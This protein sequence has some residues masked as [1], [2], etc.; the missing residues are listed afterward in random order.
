MAYTT[1]VRMF[2]K[3]RWADARVAR[4]RFDTRRWAR[5]SVELL[6]ARLTPSVSFLGVGAGDASSNDAILWTR[7]QDSATATGVALMAQVSTDQ[8]FATGLATFAGITDP[9]HDYTIHIDATGL[10]SGTRYYYR[11]VASDGTL[12]QVG[13]F[14]T[15][16]DPTAHVAVNS[17]FTGD[18]DGLMRPYDASDSPSFAPPGS[19]DFGPQNFDYF[20]WLGDTIYETASGQGTP[21]NSP[22][23]ANTNPPNIADYWRKYR[24]QFLPVSTGPYAG[25]QNFFDSNGHYTLL[26]NHELGNKQFINGGAPQGSPPGAGADATNPANDVNTTGA[27]MNQ[28]VGFQT[29][30]QAYTDYQPIRQQI[31]NT[32]GDPRSNGTQRLYFDQQWGANSIFFN[33][34]DRSYRDI[35][36]KT[37]GGADD[38]GPRADNPGR[39]MLG[40]TQLAWVE[41]GLLDAQNNG[42]TWKFVAVSSPIDQIGPVGGSFT[43]NNSGD[44]GTTQPGFTSSESD[45]GKSWMGEYRPERNALL[46]FIADNHI[47]HVVFLSTDDHQV[48]INELG[49]FTQFTTNSL[50]FQTPVQSSYTRAPGVFEIVDGPIGATGPDTITDHSFANIQALA[51]SFASQQQ[52]AGIDPIGLDAGFPGLTNVS[53]EGDPTAGTSPSP[54]DFYSPDTFNYAALNVSAAGSTLTVT[55]DGINSY[56][57]NTFPQPG[58]ANPVRQ[59]LQFQV[60]LAPVN[61]AVSPATATAGGTTTL[62]ARLTDT[63]TGA[64]IANATLTFS[65]NGHVV[66]TATT[67]GSGTA[68]L[69]NV[70][71]AGLLPGHYAGAVTVHFAGDAGHQAGN[72]SGSLDVLPA[73]DVTDQLHVRRNGPKMGPKDGTFTA[74]LT[75]TNAVRSPSLTGLF[76]IQLNNL[77]PG[78][79]LQAA[80]VTVGGVT[81]NLTITHDAAGDPIINVPAAVATS[82]AAGQSLPAIS[83]VFSNPGNKHFDFDT[84]VFLDPLDG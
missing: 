73:R 84:A 64:P 37:T 72:G 51:Q 17:G 13:T 47:D 45:G 3:R 38:T 81:Y 66:G 31:V 48:R 12:S 4:R 65:L 21:N 50:G 36:M 67:D 8:T 57:V 41:Q 61:V 19:A 70:S 40:A 18:A 7:A 14:V 6:E 16:P 43:I 79:T 56:A 35:R 23:V 34:D 24:Q 49:Y 25:L 1:E 63:G 33:L 11:F 44:P 32:P 28:T 10:A 39:T 75:I 2:T 26:D 55:I 42:T 29:L 27:Y 71:V 82:L 62:T 53:R 9:A 60:A 59:I 20:V 83:L 76:A 52:A 58:S 46:K 5:L 80:T 68:T 77:T 22:A 78:V 30:I 69:S 74:D 54:V 15:A